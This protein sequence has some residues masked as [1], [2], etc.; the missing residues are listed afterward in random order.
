MPLMCSTGDTILYSMMHEDH[1]AATVML[2]ATHTFGH[3]LQQDTSPQLLLLLLQP[4]THA[5]TFAEVCTSICVCFAERD[6][7][8]RRNQE[9]STVDA[10]AAAGS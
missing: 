4:L 1:A 9:S 8:A 10:D 6:A 7:A 2:D 3:D 5:E